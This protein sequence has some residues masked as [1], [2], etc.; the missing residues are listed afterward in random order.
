MGGREA[1]LPIYM[2]MLAREHTA[3]LRRR[4]QMKLGTTRMDAERVAKAEF[5]LV[6]FH[7][8]HLSPILMS[9]G[10]LSALCHCVEHPEER[11]HLHRFGDLHDQWEGKHHTR[12]GWLLPIKW[13]SPC[14]VYRGTFR[15]FCL[16]RM[17]GRMLE[18][19]F[20]DCL[21]FV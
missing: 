5:R 2:I 18:S 1:D 14:S 6:C 8:A 12:A 3:M 7:T 13:R 15:Q 19:E 20:Y 16:T 11:D 10:K 17:G 9:G 4:R 21:I